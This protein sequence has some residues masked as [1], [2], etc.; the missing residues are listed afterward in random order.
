[1]VARRIKAHHAVSY[2]AYSHLSEHIEAIPYLPFALRKDLL[3]IARCQ[4][5]PTTS[6]RLRSQISLGKQHKPY[7]PIK[8]VDLGWPLHS[9]NSCRFRR[10]KRILK[11]GTLVGEIASR[12]EGNPVFSG[13]ISMATRTL[14]IRDPEFDPEEE[15]I[16]SAMKEFNTSQRERRPS[17]LDYNVWFSS[18]PRDVNLP[19]SPY[20]PPCPEINQRIR[21]CLQEFRRGVSSIRV[22]L[23]QITGKRSVSR[24]TA[25]L[26]CES[27]EPP[28]VFDK[29]VLPR[30]LERRYADTGRHVGGY[31]EMRQVWTYGDLKPRTYFAFGGKSFEASKYIR[32]MANLLANSFLETGFKSRFSYNDVS[33]T[34]S[35]RLFTYDYSTFTTNLAE[36]KYFLYALAE[37]LKGT[38]MDILDTREGITTI[39]AGQ[40][41]EEY[42]RVTTDEPEFTLQYLFPDEEFQPYIQV[43]GGFLGVYG[44]IATATSMHGMHASQICGPSTLSKCVGD[45]V[46]ASGEREQDNIQSYDD[47]IEAVQSLGDIQKAKV[48]RWEDDG[49]DNDAGEATGWHYTKRPIDRIGNNIILGLL[50]E[51]PMYGALC[52]ENDGIHQGEQDLQTRLRSAAHQ[53]FHLIRKARESIG[54]DLQEEDI[55]LILQSLRPVYAAFGVPEHGLLP[56]ERIYG[57]QGLLFLPIDRR[58]F[59]DGWSSIQFGVYDPTLPVSIPVTIGSDHSDSFPLLSSENDDYLAPSDKFY[60][61]MANMGYVVLEPEFELALMTYAE[62]LRLYNDILLRERRSLYRIRV[63]DTLPFW[64]SDLQCRLLQL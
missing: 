35:R 7:A 63:V 55:E 42:T 6:A 27:F 31:A 48:Q 60:S 50:L 4:L 49:M 30:D 36:Q 21:R 16:S 26:Y 25:A 22:S 57:Y 44:N 61:F 3:V 2:T 8:Y 51:F 59:T 5:D 10:S 38:P 14:P 37:F 28:L 40:M 9:S 19:L 29:E 56:C 32:E 23:P 64:T 45:D 13:F 12:C 20:L 54:D 17:V 24:S 39:D 41:L 18:N 34:P 53:S 62:Y 43:I 11:P 47:T 58:V 33:L 52:P 1:M 15:R 46:L